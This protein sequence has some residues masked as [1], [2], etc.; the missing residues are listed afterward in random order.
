MY[1][2][3]E[4]SSWGKGGVSFLDSEVKGRALGRMY[5]ITRDQLDDVSWQEGCGKIWYNNSVKL[6]EDKGT[7]IITITNKA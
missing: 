7:E 2:G 4:S 3:N 5:L 1:Y 6:G